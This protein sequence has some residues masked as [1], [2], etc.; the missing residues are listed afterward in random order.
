MARVIGILK[1]I[2]FGSRAQ[3]F[4]RPLYTTSET[5]PESLLHVFESIHNN[6]LATPSCHS[7]A[8]TFI[9]D[10]H[11]PIRFHLQEPP[12]SSP[13]PSHHRFLSR[14]PDWRGIPQ[15]YSYSIEVPLQPGVNHVVWCNHSSRGGVSTS[16]LPPCDGDWPSISPHPTAPELAIHFYSLQ[17]GDSGAVNRLCYK[18]LPR[19]RFSS[20]PLTLNL[21]V[22]Q[23]LLCTCRAGQYHH[24]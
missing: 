13:V 3:N 12:P 18:R 8:M 24:C 16:F 2:V 1:N 14:F 10:T 9:L 21:I 11:L 15:Q 5:N 23:P 17:G 4:C 19:S 22:L 6:T 20:H 7:V